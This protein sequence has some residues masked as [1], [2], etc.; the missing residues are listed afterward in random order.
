MLARVLQLLLVFLEG[1]GDRLEEMTYK[2]SAGP[3]N[4]AAWGK[5]CRKHHKRGF[6]IMLTDNQRR[7]LWA[8]ARISGLNFAGR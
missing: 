1:V 7:A 8:M 6:S 2:P 3:N 4:K 5:N